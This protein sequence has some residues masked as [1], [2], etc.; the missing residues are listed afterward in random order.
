[1]AAF[2][3]A[4]LRTAARAEGI[5]DLGKDERNARHIALPARRFNRASPISRT[6]PQA[7]FAAERNGPAAPG[8]CGHEKD[9]SATIKSH[10][11]KA[12]ACAIVSVM[13]L[14]SRFV[15]RSTI[16]LLAVGFLTLLG[17]VLMTSWLNE[18]AQTY[19]NEVME[20]RTTREA[21]VELRNALQAAESSQRGFLYTDNE[22]YFEPYKGDKTLALRQL[23]RLKAALAPYPEA[24]AMLRR[25][26]EIVPEK[27]VEMDHVI[28][29]MRQHKADEALALVRT[30]RG[31]Q[32][33]DEA[34]VFLTGIIVKADERLTTGVDEQRRN[35]AALRWA[36]I[37]GGLVIVLVVGGVVTTAAR[38]TRELGQARDQVRALN[39]NLEQ[40]VEERTADLA[41]ARDRA[42]V[43]LSEVN[44]RVANSLTLVTSLVHLQRNAV[45]DQ[46][47]KTALDETQARIFAISSVHRRLYTSGDVRFVSLDE[48]LSSLLD[49]LATSMRNEGH[50][51]TLR[52]QLEPLQLPTD[53]SVNLG[54]VAIELV[55]NAF[56]YAYPDRNGEVRVRLKNLPDR[57][58]ELVV[59]D[60]GVGFT[61]GAP[62]RGTG[63]GTRIVKAM[64]ATMNADI[65]YVAR[66]PGTGARLTFALAAQ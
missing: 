4:G 49:Q 61:D 60:D 50:G 31:K 7:H 11:C 62:A 32:L 6:A 55:T 13:P 39:A 54:V 35:A 44:H 58:V 19:F 42:E 64:A 16:S 15:V 36:S 53:A 10:V 29:L 56:K 2:F 48:Y 12:R 27:F 65:Q 20:A 66:T 24:E 30:N 47:A 46:A 52:Y 28:A 38:Y 9:A 18:R 26:D 17:I 1:L 25:L 14:T 43:L 22:I 8:A 41:R 51:A 59:E 21:A 34:H 5:R 37:A 40:R 63:L 57:K 3:A 33:M 45:A 23:D